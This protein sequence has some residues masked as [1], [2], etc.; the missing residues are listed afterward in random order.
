[1]SVAPFSFNSPVPHQEISFIF[2]VGLF[3]S[4][5]SVYMPIYFLGSSFFSFF[6]VF[7]RRYF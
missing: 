3:P 7:L 6:S 1:M 4:S 2:S 5:Y